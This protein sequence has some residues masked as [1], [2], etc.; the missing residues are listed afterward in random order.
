M[1]AEMV[2]IYQE[3]IVLTYSTLLLDCPVLSGNMQHHIEWEEVGK[4]FARIVI[5]AP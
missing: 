1:D 3:L 2:A 4:D 5:K